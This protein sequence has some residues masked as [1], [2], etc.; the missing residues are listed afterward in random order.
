M[1]SF[2]FFTIEAADLLQKLSLESK[3]NTLEIPEPTK[4]ASVDSTDVT[5]G[6]TQSG[7]RSL[8]PLL[9]DF[10][11]PAVCYVPNG[12][13]YTAY[14]YGAYDGTGNEWENYPRYLNQDGVEMPVS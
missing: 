14:H 12:Y 1:D 2:T 11:D 9:P 13:P 7:D 3:P 10:I 4:K 6:Q 8:T 5:N